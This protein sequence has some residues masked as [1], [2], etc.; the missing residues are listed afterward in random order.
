MEKPGYTAT[1]NAN[2]IYQIELEKAGSYSARL[3]GNP[4]QLDLVQDKD[5]RMH[6]LRDNRSY[7][8][9]VLN[10]DKLAKTV[11]LK[12]NGNRY[13]V[14]LT[15][16][17]DALLKS[18]GMD[19]VTSAKLNEL[20]APMPGLVLDIVITEGQAVQKGDALVVLEA[21]KMENILKSP[22]SGVVKKIMVKK[23]TPVEKNQVLI[24]FGA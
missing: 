17:F 11:T 10:M 7:S 18:L 22:G 16:K 19:A 14:Q 9:E 20:K 21:M 15:D 2:Q 8:V 5:G 24:Q 4:V 23:G 3:N 13:D 1:V 6:V 12:I